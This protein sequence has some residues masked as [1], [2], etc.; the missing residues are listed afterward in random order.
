MQSVTNFENNDILTNNSMLM[1]H[2][3]N[4]S[5]STSFPR[6][7]L[8]QAVVVIDGWKEVGN[9]LMVP[10]LDLEQ[11]IRKLNEAQKYL[12]RAEEL[13]RERSRAI[14]ERNALLSEV[15]DLT[16]RIRNAAK[17]TFGDHS[18]ELERLVTSVK[19]ENLNSFQER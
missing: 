2:H 14:Q 11:Y 6:D 5:K 4:L 10:N 15:W 1:N 18:P 16:K 3:V 12:I 8:D 17:A 19:T 9:K 13:K 7:A